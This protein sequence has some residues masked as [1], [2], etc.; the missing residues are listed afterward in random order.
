MPES[1]RLHAISPDTATPDIFLAP[2]IMG[3]GKSKNKATP[4]QETPKDGKAKKRASKRGS[5]RG[6]GSGGSQRRKSKRERKE[7]RSSAEKIRD[8]IHGQLA[9]HGGL[10][11]MFASIDADDSKGISFKEFCAFVKKHNGR[12]TKEEY[13]QAFDHI[14][15]DGNGTIE[16]GEFKVWFAPI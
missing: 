4:A 9:K 3:C 11:G 7:D 12:F 15:D 8:V 16:F 14:D 2:P 10:G 13:R 5:R 1:V 6:G